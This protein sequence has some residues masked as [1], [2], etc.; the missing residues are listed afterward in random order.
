MGGLNATRQCTPCLDPNCQDCGQDHRV[1][2]NCQMQYVA[3]QGS[4]QPCRKG[5]ADC[6]HPEDG[7]PNDP[8]ALVHSTCT[9]KGVRKA[10]K[11]GWGRVGKKCVQCRVKHCTRCDGDTSLC[12]ACG[13]APVDYYMLYPNKKRT[14]CIRCQAHSQCQECKGAY[15]PCTVCSNGYEE[16]DGTG[17]AVVGGT[18]TKCRT[19]CPECGDDPAA[20]LFCEP[21]DVCWDYAEF[22][23]R[24]GKCVNFPNY[25]YSGGC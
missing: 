22:D 16:A 3:V 7:C 14:T 21:V 4:C 1:C 5:C 13:P 18:C 17:W 9:T 20:C 6:G 25:N 24:T 23:P 10:C 19:G 8:F 11:K 15:G 12:Q 2:T